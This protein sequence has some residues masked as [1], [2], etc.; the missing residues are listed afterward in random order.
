MHE[1]THN[2]VSYF[3]Y[4]FTISIGYDDN[5]ILVHYCIIILACMHSTLYALG[6]CPSQVDKIKEELNK[7]NYRLNEF[8]KLSVF[9]V[10]EFQVTTSLCIA[11]FDCN[12]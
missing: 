9:T 8:A 1:T 7:F 5:A 3:S 4:I 6:H 10:D 2:Y 12:K 11:V